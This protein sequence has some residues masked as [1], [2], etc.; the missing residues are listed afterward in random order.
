MSE[1]AT[2]DILSTTYFLVYTINPVLKRAWCRMAVLHYHRGAARPSTSPR[3]VRTRSTADSIVRTAHRGG[4][5]F[6]PGC[7]SRPPRLRSEDA[8]ADDG[9]YP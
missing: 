4:L 9:S 3:R 2:T 7:M 8:C 5:A 1:F 6:G